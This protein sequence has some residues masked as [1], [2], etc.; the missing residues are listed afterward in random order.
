MKKTLGILRITL[1][2]SLILI[3]G[4]CGVKIKK[5]DLRLF[6]IRGEVC[7]YSKLNDKVKCRKPKNDYIAIS[8]K[9]LGCFRKNL[10]RMFDYVESA[11]L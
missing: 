5:C 7:R 1:I 8:R 4:G 3:C 11:K 2:V 6:K 9:G 10:D